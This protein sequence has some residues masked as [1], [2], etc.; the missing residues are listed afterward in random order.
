[1]RKTTSSTYKK[2]LL[3][4][5][6]ELPPWQQKFSRLIHA[7]LM[8]SFSSLLTSVF[9]RSNPLLIA[10][11]IALLGGFVAFVVASVFNYQV[12]SFSFLLRLFGLGF[13]IG[14]IFEY[15]K[16]LGKR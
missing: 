15:L 4:S 11:L 6:R 7:P 1:M 14:L 5:Q 16:N 3:R 2:I 8:R 12:V 13:I 10:S 9:F